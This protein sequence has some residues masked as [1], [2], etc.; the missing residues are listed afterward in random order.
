MVCFCYLTG[1]IAFIHQL[2]QWPV[3][4]KCGR[5]GTAGAILP[6]GQIR[7]V[8]ADGAEADLQKG[9]T[10]ELLIRGPYVALGYY[11]DPEA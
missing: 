7:I 5:F 8:K 1:P 11:K 6:A 2:Y 9:E 4:P 10:G 3:S